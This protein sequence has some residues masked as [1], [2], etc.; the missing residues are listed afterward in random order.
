MRG[1]CVCVRLWHDLAG[2]IFNEDAL[3]FAAPDRRGGGA[4]A[5]FHEIPKNRHEKSGEADVE[6][7]VKGLARHARMVPVLEVAGDL[8][9][10]RHA[11]C[12]GAE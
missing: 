3:D 6:A 9:Q 12:H 2:S 11:G 1:E 10:R 8:V 4:V 5:L 7:L